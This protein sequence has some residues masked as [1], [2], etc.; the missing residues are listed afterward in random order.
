MALAVACGGGDDGA[1]PATAGSSAPVDEGA[2]GVVVERV[3]AGGYALEAGIEEGDRLLRWELRDDSEGE[4]GASGDITSPFDLLSLEVEEAPRGAL[5][6]E[7]EH[8]GERRRVRMVD[9]L[10]R[11]FARPAFDDPVAV[12]YGDAV[13]AADEKPEEGIEMLERLAEERKAVSPTE[14]VWL[15][16]R[17][18]LARKEARLVD[19]LEEHYRRAAR[20]AAEIGEPESAAWILHLGGLALEAQS[21][22]PVASDLFAEALALFESVAPGSL[23]EA[24]LMDSLG[25]NRIRSGDREGGFELLQRALA[26]RRELVPGSLTVARS[27]TTLGNNSTRLQEQ[28]QL[29]EEAVRIRRRL[30]PGSLELALSLNNLGNIRWHRRDL[31]GAQALLEEAERLLVEIGADARFVAGARGNLALVAEDRGELAIAER[32]ILETLAFFAREEPGGAWHAETLSILAN[33][34][35]RRGDLWGAREAVEQALELWR[36]VEP[37]G[38]GEAD[39]LKG[40]GS[41]AG[42]LEEWDEARRLYGEATKIYRAIQPD[43]LGQAAAEQGLGH[44][45]KQAGDYDAAEKAYSRARSIWRTLTPD[46][47]TVAAAEINLGDLELARD[48]PAKAEAHL[49]RAVGLIHRLAPNSYWMVGCTSSLGRALRRQGRS[50]EALGVYRQGLE[51]LEQQLG[52]LGADQWERAEYRARNLDLY[53]ETI[54]LLLEEGLVDEAFEVLERSRAQALLELFAGRDLRFAGEVPAELEG[55]RSRIAF[56]RR[57]AEQRLVALSAKDDSAE[58]AALQAELAGLAGRERELDRALARNSPRVAALRHPHAVTAQEASLSLPEGATALVYQVGQE[59]S[60]LF[61]LTSDGA[62]RSVILDAGEEELRSL[63]RRF[64]LL[65]SGGPVGAGDPAVFDQIAT[66]LFDLLVAPAL[67]EAASAR[68]LLL[69]PDGPLHFLPF[70]ALRPPAALLPEVA[71]PL[72]YL[73]TWKPYH[74]V[75]SLTVLRELEDTPVGVPVPP[76]VTSLVAFGD[77]LEGDQRSGKE[78]AQGR[79]EAAPLPYSRE[80]VEAIGSSFARA[81]TYLGAAASEDEALR[82]EGEIP[83]LHFATHS[84]LDHRRPLESALVLSPPAQPAGVNDDGL[85]QAWEIVERL[86]IHCRLVVLSGCETA[87]GRELRGEGLVGLTRAFQFAGARSVLASLWR[88]SDA[89]TSVLMRHFYERLDGG[90]GFAE[91]LR[92][93]QLELMRGE[94]TASEGGPDVSSLWHRLAVGFG[95]F[96]REGP[97]SRRAEVQRTMHPYYWAAFQ[98]YGAP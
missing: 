72:R 26:L 49:R 68:E 30:A 42:E 82:L 81:R 80:E 40:L 31:A 50:Q 83:Y 1:P 89:S 76:R 63:V 69:V 34:R 9:R 41:V 75:L 62:L 4:V 5:W 61:V 15:L 20:A 98:L 16:Y 6:L 65:I 51:A 79:A 28:E 36:R 45:L 39:A 91:A 3:N 35:R 55:E 77:P 43:G 66:R 38:L 47:L 84:I 74:L 22:Y 90:G 78:G 10:W 48:Q 37:G 58:V 7:L 54:D 24:W 33:L 64:R 12:A 94:G 96:W 17:V 93:T 25:E 13:A 14:G 57:R 19:R 56:D 67:P 2:A 85:L 11:L 87:L 88:V 97:R 21:R 27:L 73:V 60:H 44:V 92:E 52:R 53:R 59:R 95:G 23:R 71:A 8:Q 29:H 86:R 70:A 18:A 32:R 46:S